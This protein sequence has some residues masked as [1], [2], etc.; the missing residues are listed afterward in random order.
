MLKKGSKIKL[1]RSIPSNRKKYYGDNMRQYDFIYEVTYISDKRVR[2]SYD[3]INNEHLS[4][5][6]RYLLYSGDHYS[7]L[8]E[9]ILQSIV[10]PDE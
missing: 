5:S 3:P 4:E 6:I 10:Y 7:I 8:H 2:C 9:D 1:N